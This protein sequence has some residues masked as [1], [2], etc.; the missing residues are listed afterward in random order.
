MKSLKPI[1]LCLVCCTV[2]LSLATP[3][4]ANGAPVK[5]FLNY[6]PEFSNYGPTDASGVASVSIGE[7]WVELTAHGLPPLTGDLYEAWLIQSETKEMISLG[8][9]NADA[10][11]NIAYYAELDELPIADYRYFVISVEPDPDPSPEADVRFTIAGVFPNAELQ[12]VSSTPTP[13]PGPG[14]TPTPDAPIVLPVTGGGGIYGKPAF[15]WDWLLIG[16]VVVSA[17]G[18]G[19]IVL[20]R[21]AQN[22]RRTVMIELPDVQS[23]TKS[24]E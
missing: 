20:S 4:A 13:I 9:F 5:I 11:G 17:L 8:K 22:R 1:I 19:G 15:A 18:V 2:L 16:G 21:G 6:L 14:V 3:A 24:K 12:I 10:D 23:R 7:A